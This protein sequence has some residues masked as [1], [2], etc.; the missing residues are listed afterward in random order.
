MHN[1]VIQKEIEGLEALKKRE[2]G[3][4]ETIA[5]L[6]EELAS[7][8]QEMRTREYALD[9][10]RRALGIAD[11]DGTIAE[12]PMEKRIFVDDEKDCFMKKEGVKEF[13]FEHQRHAFET[14]L[15][16]ITTMMELLEAKDAARFE[17]FVNSDL[18]K[19]RG[20]GINNLS[21]YL[22]TTAPSGDEASYWF[23]YR[24]DIW[25]KRNGL[26]IVN[27]MR[28]IEI[29]LNAFSVDR[30]SFYIIFNEKKTDDAA[31]EEG[32]E[33]DDPDQLGLDLDGEGSAND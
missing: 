28:V 8:Q 23:K 1:E 17:E 20:D 33:E 10:A 4:V 9:L 3:I 24:D 18:S 31:D 5:R 22:S 6:K 21:M 25:V 14:R 12:P 26:G 29:L 19:Y 27:T 13:W 2:S 32:Y 15:R 16:M 30:H 7:I 11:E